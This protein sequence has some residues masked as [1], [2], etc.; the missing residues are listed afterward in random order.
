MTMLDSHHLPY[1]FAL[2][3]VYVVVP[4]YNEAPIIQTTLEGILGQKS[5]RD[6][7][8]V[9]A[10]AHVIVVANGCIDETASIARELGAT[11]IETTARG[12]AFAR[13]LGAR[14]V[15]DH[16]PVDDVY[17]AFLDADIEVTNPYLLEA[18]LFKLREGFAGVIAPRRSYGGS[19]ILD[20]LFD[21]LNNE[22]LRKPLERVP[23]GYLFV[24]ARVYQ[25][26]HTRHGV[27]R[28]DQE[29]AE[30]L[31]FG[32]LLAVLP[33]TR[34][35]GIIRITNRTYARR[36]RKMGYLGATFNT[37]RTW[38]NRTFGTKFKERPY[39]DAPTQKTP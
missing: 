25:D 22:I 39:W 13:N 3:S 14:Y 17:I 19:M 23:K 15:L 11:V 34:G 38:L 31:H 7:A 16:T 33:G 10:P 8:S 27:Y 12:A 18:S 24:A 28:Q 6:P 32:R 26:L 37:T 20:Y 9:F 35:L 1:G 5:S 21:I 36:Y 29:P 30:D 2:D 4:A